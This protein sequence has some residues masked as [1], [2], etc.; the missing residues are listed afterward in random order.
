VEEAYPIAGTVWALVYVKQ[1]ADKMHMLTDFLSWV[2]H[3]GQK[4]C[5]KLHYANLPPV[6][7]QK[8]EGKLKLIEGGK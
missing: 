6:L 5:E 2:T 7:V 8:I 3:Q 4:H 1:P